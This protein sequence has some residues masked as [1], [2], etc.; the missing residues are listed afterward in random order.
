[1]LL[2][3]LFASGATAAYAQA[4]QDLRE[5]FGLKQPPA[6]RVD[7]GDG[8]AFDCAIATDPLDGATLYALST[9]LPVSWVGRLPVGAA[10][11]DAVASYALGASRDGAGVVLGGG[12]GLD[13]RWTID[14]APADSVRTG[15]ADTRVPLAFLEGV[16]VTAGGFAARDRASVGG[17]IDARL[18]RGTPKHELAAEAW[19][20]LAR[21]ASTP[22]LPVGAYRV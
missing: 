9:W 1:M 14:G 3:G 20:E 7:C 19:L 13:N 22:P 2:A 18:L 10:S 15:G 6:G 17:T 4:P 11:H 8:L 5:T 12:T 21:A 16:L